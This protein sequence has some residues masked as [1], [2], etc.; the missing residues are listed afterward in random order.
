VTTLITKITLQH[1]WTGSIISQIL[2]PW[3]Y[4]GSAGLIMFVTQS[5]PEIVKRISPVCTNGKN[6]VK[7]RVQVRVQVMTS[8]VMT[9]WNV[10]R[11]G[12][13]WLESPQIKPSFTR[14]KTLNMCTQGCILQLL[15]LS[16]WKFRGREDPCDSASINNQSGTIHNKTN[17]W[18]F[19]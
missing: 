13:S 14:D 8:G 2:H 6:N 10:L 11:V 7:A 15:R 9:V 1:T 12:K 18:T 4:A 16:Q 19:E 17:Y 3:H 5:Q